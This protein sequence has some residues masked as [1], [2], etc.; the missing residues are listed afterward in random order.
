MAQTLVKIYVHV[1]F[2]TKN[3]NDLISAEIEKE[4]FAYI[5]G[6][7]RKH[8]TVL[9]AANGTANHVH[10]LISLSKNIA[11]SD[12]L[13]EL[14]KASSFWVKTKDAE[15]KNFQWQSGFGAFS[16]GQS[17]IETVKNYIAKQKDHHKIELFENEYRKFLQKYEIDFDEN[18]FLD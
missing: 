3:R 18:Y 13:R 2:S 14:K 12:L 4:L 9:L 17:Q 8:Q 15:F 11:L 5:G 10:L 6:I 1:V 7:L 16:I